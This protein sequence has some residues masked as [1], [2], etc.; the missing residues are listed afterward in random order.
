MVFHI[1]QKFQEKRCLYDQS[2]SV[3]KKDPAHI[4]TELTAAFLKIRKDLFPLSDAELL[5]RVHMTE[6]TRIVRTPYCNLYDQAPGLTGRPVNVSLV[7][8]SL[9]LFCNIYVYSYLSSMTRFVFF[10]LLGRTP[11]STTLTSGV[12]PITDLTFFAMLSASL[13]NSTSPV[14]ST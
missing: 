7:L 3:R 1:G 10:S 2:I 6:G 8:H 5:A 11:T 14:V 9:P 4:F 13:R 12:K